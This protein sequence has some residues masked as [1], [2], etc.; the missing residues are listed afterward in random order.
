MLA[1]GTHRGAVGGTQTGP[2]TGEKEVKDEDSQGVD[3]SVGLSSP[4]PSSW[5]IP[6]PLCPLLPHGGVWGTLRAYCVCAA[7]SRQEHCALGGSWTGDCE[8]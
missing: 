5:P 4:L 8:G 6:S 2:A 3:P 1:V 7:G